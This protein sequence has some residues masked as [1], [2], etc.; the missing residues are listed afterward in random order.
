MALDLSEAR[1]EATLAGDRLNA[2]LGLQSAR[3][4]RLDGRGWLTLAQQGWRLGRQPSRRW[5]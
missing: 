1:L 2:T 4:G 3:F 5:K